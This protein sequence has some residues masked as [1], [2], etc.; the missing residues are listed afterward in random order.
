MFL[1]LIT[2]FISQLLF[3]V[4]Y[5][6]NLKVKVMLTCRALQLLHC[7]LSSAVI[8]D[9]AGIQC[10]PQFAQARAHGL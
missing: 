2:A 1:V 7:S 10:K 8:T 9:R 4:F 5:H 6:F 3:L